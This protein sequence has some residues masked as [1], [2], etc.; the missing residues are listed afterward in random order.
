VDKFLNENQMSKKRGE[1][2]KRKA[3]YS[4]S[5]DSEWR[6]IYQFFEDIDSLD[7]VCFI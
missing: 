3:G 5:E 2:G 4:Y 1:R 6:G 7:L